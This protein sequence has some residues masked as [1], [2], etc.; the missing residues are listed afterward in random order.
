MY[1]LLYTLRPRR[2]VEKF[3]LLLLPRTERVRRTVY[4]ITSYTDGDYNIIIIAG[5]TPFRTRR[6]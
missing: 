6:P 5:Q 3:R 2:R 4:I 1:I